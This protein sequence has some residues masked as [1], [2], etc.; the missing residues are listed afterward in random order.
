MARTP[1]M[2]GIYPSELL[3]A[4]LAS[5]SSPPHSTI[6][7]DNKGASQVLNS[8]KK[9]VRH[10]FLVSVTRKSVQEK[11]QTVKW[12]K[13][14]VGHRGN[15]LADIYAR[16]ACS[17]PQQKPAQTTDPFSVVIG[18]LPHLPPHKCWTEANVPLHRHTGI[19]PISFTPLKR[20]PDSL[21]WIKWLFGLCWRPGWQPYQSF[22]SRTPSRRACLSC[23]A[24]HN[25]SI[26]GTLAFCDSHPLRQAWLQAWDKHPLVLQWLRTI[27]TNDRV[28]VGKACIPL[29]LYH[30][31]A[32][33]LGRA[34]SRRLI[35][36][37]QRSIMHLLHTCLDSLQ[38]Q[39]P[40][41]TPKSTR[42]RIWMEA[43]WDTQGAGV[44]IL[45][46][47]SAKRPLTQGTL[48]FI[49]RHA[50]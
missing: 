41:P 32:S 48:S 30:H 38:P 14:H 26:N 8:A 7:L 44:H 12:I 13:G 45:R 10:A 35:F 9:V 46:P 4:Y 29:T 43:D 6:H 1:G 21:S 36:A 23:L 18:G 37:F 11:H 17:L 19:H 42:K 25:T 31:L 5:R 15:E 39:V 49:L 3:G 27:S 33:N 20:S 24:F 22:W 40:L 2:Q 28:L 34:A 16:K 50:I 47:R